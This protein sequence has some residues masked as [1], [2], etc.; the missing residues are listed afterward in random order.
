MY[1]Q[2]ASDSNANAYQGRHAGCGGRGRHWGRHFGQRGHR[3]GP[4]WAK[5]FGGAWQ[6]VPV[7]IETT[8]T[9]FVLSLFA[10]GLVKENISLT[11]QHDVLTIAYQGTDTASDDA[12]PDPRYT[13]REFRNASFERAF[14]LNGKVLTDGITA[15]YAEGILTVTLPKNP[16]TNQPAQT[17]GVS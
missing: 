1:T 14:Q 4:P 15:A 2:Q 16:A 5:F 8:E 9:S 11:V 7:N 12:A 17:I 13:R 6:P 3:G 10:A